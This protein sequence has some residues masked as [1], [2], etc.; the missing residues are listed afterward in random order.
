MR[1]TCGQ[2][3]ECSHDVRAQ[4]DRRISVGPDQ[5]YLPGNMEHRVKV[6]GKGALHI[7]DLTHV[8]L[9]KTCRCRN[10]FAQTSGKIINHHDF[11]PV[12]E[13]TIHHVRAD[14]ASSTRYQNTHDFPR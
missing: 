9:D 6:P 10:I 13:Q 1:D 11:V 7:F 8:A 14:E 12:S 4:V 3:I 2:D 5:R